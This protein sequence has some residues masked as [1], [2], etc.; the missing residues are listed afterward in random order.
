M[1]DKKTITVVA[2]RAKLD[3]LYNQVIKKVQSKEVMLLDKG[4]T[5]K[6]A[7]EKDKEFVDHIGVIFSKR[8]NINDVQGGLEACL[9]IKYLKITYTNNMETLE[10]SSPQ[11]IEI[12]NFV[13]IEFSYEGTVAETEASVPAINFLI[14]TQHSK[15]VTL[16][17]CSTKIGDS[18]MLSYDVPNL[19][20]VLNAI[21]IKNC[22]FKD[23]SII[24]AS[25]RGDNKNAQR[26]AENRAKR[27]E[28]I[29]EVHVWVV[30]DKNT[31]RRFLINLSKSTIIKYTYRYEAILLNGNDMQQFIVRGDCPNILEWG[32]GEK[33][34][35]N[36]IK[37]Y[38]LAI[39]K[40]GRGQMKDDLDLMQVTKQNIGTNKE[41]FMR[42]RKLAVDKGDRFQESI[43]NYH[44]AKCDEQL[45]D[46]ETDKHF[47][48]DK[49]IMFLGKHLSRHG[50]SWL[51]PLL[52]I[53][54]F[55]ILASSIIY[56]ILKD[57]VTPYFIFD[58]DFRYI[59][60]EL[61]NPLGMPANIVKGIDKSFSY[62]TL[63][64][65]Y[66]DVASLVLLS[67]AFYA[68]CIYEFVR[69]ARRFTLK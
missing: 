40:D 24:T 50:T 17:R 36:I 48:Q 57:S 56:F 25:K 65:S 3:L 31:F 34:G 44:I 54:V 23:F 59:S 8:T 29:N 27:P 69:A 60:T 62:E 55:N 1:A 49:A 18:L 63:G 67:K 52:Y 9:Y 64:R 10:I 21:N 66:I 5:F 47:S 26:V 53:I 19:S 11:V 35:E 22:D 12:L 33:I 14:A 46:L 28:E 42:I 58:L 38:K 2:L 16:T 41:S 30:L 13:H 39:N 7:L 37:D 20:D 61:L 51:R 15:V 68:V 32:T 45:I 43:I 4:K 6:V